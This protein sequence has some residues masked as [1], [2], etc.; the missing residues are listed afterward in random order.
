MDNNGPAFGSDQLSPVHTGP[1]PVDATLLSAERREK[2]GA[3]P[4]P[5][6]Q[7]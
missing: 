7:K 5:A 2:K 3:G 1:V 4:F 6:I